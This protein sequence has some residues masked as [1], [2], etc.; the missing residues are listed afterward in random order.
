MY[1]RPK[2][3]SRNDESVIDEELFHL[4]LEPMRLR[5]EKKFPA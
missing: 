1:G 2:A 3:A 5:V 4:F